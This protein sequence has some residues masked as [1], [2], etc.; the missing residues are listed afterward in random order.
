MPRRDLASLEFAVRG[1]TNTPYHRFRDVRPGVTRAGSKAK[2]YRSEPGRG[3]R[4]R[5]ASLVHR[6]QHGARAVPTR[7][8]GG[9]VPEPLRR[10]RYGRRD[11]GPAYN[12]RN[13]SRHGRRHGEHQRHQPRRLYLRDRRSRQRTVELHAVVCYWE[14]DYLQYVVV[15]VDRRVR[16][17]SVEVMGLEPTT[18]TLRT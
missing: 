7:R 6:Q 18:S 17:T 15:D 12:I 10:R 4:P 1:A 9:V 11:P 13:V 8:G 3:T 5:H 2:G 16:K 14:W